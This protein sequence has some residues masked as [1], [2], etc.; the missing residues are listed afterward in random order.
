ML[1][2]TNTM[3]N[4]ELEDFIESQFDEKSNKKIQVKDDDVKEL[5]YIKE[6]IF[7]MPVKK[8]T[9]FKSKQTEYKNIYN[10]SRINY[11]MKINSNLVKK[12]VKKRLFKTLIYSA[13]IAICFYLVSTS[14]FQDKT[15]E[16][17][18][19]YWGKFKIYFK[20]IIFWK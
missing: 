2:D 10:Q 15:K 5:Y 13:S 18:V 7:L 9:K 8:Y 6:N 3:S 14:G 1:N 17:T 12:F 20:K 19:E 4:K 16:K 11:Y